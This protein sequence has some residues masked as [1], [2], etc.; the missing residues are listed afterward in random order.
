MQRFWWVNHNSTA[1]QEVGGQYLWSPKRDANGARNQAYENMRLAGPGDLVFSYSGQALRF[2][3]RVADF[4]FTSPKPPE[5][6]SIGSNW[7][8]IGWRIPVFWT[9][10][11]TPVRPSLFFDDLRPLL[12]EKNGPLT[13]LGGGSQKTYLAE[14]SPPAFRLIEQSASFDVEALATGGGNHLKFEALI[15]ELE[16]DIE[17][18]IDGDPALET[19]TKS[20]LIQARR[21]QGKFRQNV[22]RVEDA[23]RITGITNSALLIASHIKPWRLCS[24]AQERLDGMNG[25]MLTPDA[26]HLFDRGFISFEDGGKVRV[27]SRVDRFDLRRLGLEHLAPA[28]TGFEEAS[29]PWL[30]AGF[31]PSQRRYLDYHRREVFIT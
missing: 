31:E 24:T 1:R 4:A 23:C 13:R 29:L 10:L 21:G 25:L 15:E 5:F 16:D 19:T 14:L 7:S 3:G 9:P 20:S 11:I 27:S 8:N 17:R 2:V 28:S 26:D 18:Q 12:P 6:G 22:E 30:A